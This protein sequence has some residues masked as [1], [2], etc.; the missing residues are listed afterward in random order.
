MCEPRLVL[1]QAWPVQ[2]SAEA[3]AA[4]PP[5]GPG[6]LRVDGRARDVGEADA[7]AGAQ[8]EELVLFSVP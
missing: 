6:E 2:R 3:P 4:P 1:R 7:E 5:P 8:G